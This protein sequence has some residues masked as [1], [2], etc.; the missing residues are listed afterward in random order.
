MIRTLLTALLLALLCAA[1]LLFGARPDVGFGDLAGLWSVP[2]SDDA[3]GIVVREMRLPRTLAALIAGAALG[4]AGA[5][6]QT[7]TRNPLADPGLL[8]VNAGAALGIVASV[9]IAGPLSHDLLV[10]PAMA[11]AFAALLIVWSIGAASRSPLTLI[12]AGAAV[13]ALL[14]ALLRALLLLD[15]Q[16]L[17]AYRDWSVGALDGTNLATVQAA[18][19]MA[20]AGFSFALPAARRLDSLALGEDLAGALGTNLAIAR[21]LT[22]GAIGILAA[23]AVLAAGP[24]AFVGLVAPHLARALALQSGLSLLAFSACF[25]AAL[26]LV[27]DIAGRVVMPG[28]VIEAGLGVTLIG[29]GFLIWLVRQQ[30]RNPA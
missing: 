12:L 27:A 19:L 11:G 21:A 2:A 1:S 18:S 28:L 8:G 20:L 16:A 4:A 17:D 10:A 3:A 15:S 30:A 23:A 26:V 24:L 13:T 5:L 7:L 9:W 25:G 29:G 22:L 14:S 6:I